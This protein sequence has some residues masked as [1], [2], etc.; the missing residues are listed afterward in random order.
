[1]PS[2]STRYPVRMS[3]L[4]Q[5]AR[6]ATEVVFVCSGNIVRSA[7]AELFGR[8]VLRLKVPLRSCATTYRNQRI[9][10][11]TERTLRLRG[12]PFEALEEFHPTFVTDLQPTPGPGSLLLAMREAHLEILREHGLDGVLLG[13]VL[14]PGREIADPV[15]EDAEFPAVF[16]E[17]EAALRAWAALTE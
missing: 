14:E 13:E 6:A 17:I 9:H 1:M 15:L 5:L 12:V 11:T 8:H 3:E 7:Y 2:A 16:A 10:V 4:Q